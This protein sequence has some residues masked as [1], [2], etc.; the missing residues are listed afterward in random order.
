MATVLTTAI[1]ALAVDDGEVPAS[2]LSVQATLGIFVGIPA[3]I[4][5]LIALLVVLPGII[6][7]PRYRPGRSWEADPMWFGAPENAQS[8]LEVTSNSIALPEGP[9]RPEVVGGGASVRW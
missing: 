5:A 9:V 4:F 6:R 8:V 3:A 1:P 2:K 7:G